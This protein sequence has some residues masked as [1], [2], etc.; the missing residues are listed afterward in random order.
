MPTKTK[1]KGTKIDT[2]EE[3]QAHP[4][5]GKLLEGGV[6]GVPFEGVGDL[7]DE[8]SLFGFRGLRFFPLLSDPTGQAQVA[9]AESKELTA[10]VAKIFTVKAHGFIVGDTVTVALDPAD[11]V[12]DGDHVIV[13]TPT[14][15]S[16]TFAKVNA[17][18]VN[19]ATGG[20][21]IVANPTLEPT[22]DSP[23]IAPPPH[24]FEL[25][26]DIL[27]HDLDGG[28][29]TLEQK[30]LIPK[31]TNKIIVPRINLSMLAGTVGGTVSFGSDGG[32]GASKFSAWVYKF[33]DK[34]PYVGIDMYVAE[35]SDDVAAA[36]VSTFKAKPKSAKLAGSGY[37]KF[38]GLFEIDFEAIP[39]ASTDEACGIYFYDD[40]FVFDSAPFPGP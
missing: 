23:L 3:A 5:F 7:A 19:G 31:W 30:N 29:R 40:T 12:F 15:K 17:D 22:Y 39:L 6:S 25:D 2:V 21:C 11:A 4:Y 18:I 34:A 16:F 26:P 33:S 37:N 24:D 35:T 1:T 27:I 9:T 14:S 13:A 38:G 36:R 10:N 32:T 28:D 8:S 20:T